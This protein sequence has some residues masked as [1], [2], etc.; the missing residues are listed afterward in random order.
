MLKHGAMFWDDALLPRSIFLQ[1]FDAL[2]KAIARSGE[3]AWLI[4]GDA[5]EYGDLA[6]VSHFL[7]RLRSAVALVVKD[8]P[9]TLMA[10][11]GSRDIPATKELTWFED[12][13][14]YWQ[15]PPELIRLVRD[16]GLEKAKIGTVGTTELLPIAEW[17]AISAELPDVRW[18]A[19][20]AAFRELR[21]APDGTRHRAILSA[22]RVL[23]DAFAA[24]K[25]SLRAGVTIRRAT[26]LIDRAAR[27]AA[28]EDVRILVATGPQCG[29]ALRP[30]DDRTPEAGDAIMLY[31]AVE[32]QRHWAS[33]ART[34]V[35][36]KAAPA[37]LDLCD[38]ARKAL[39]GMKVE[40]HLG[41]RCAD[42]A[43]AAEA[44]IAAPSLIESARSYGLG[45]G[46]GLDLE[47]PPTISVRSNEI[48]GDDVHLALD[49][50][51]HHDGIGI[52][53]GEMVHVKGNVCKRLTEGPILTELFG[54]EQSK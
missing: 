35:L 22:A 28:A 12:V 41:R 6:F 17:D 19:R 46:I 7:P 30:V 29:V 44:A 54:S 13:R 1:R 10:S 36:G 52:A 5:Q 48:I 49:I 4:Y 15:L 31:V 32:V 23:D 51:L 34:Y 20:D 38:R 39:A 33:A 2:Q 3:D 40:L 27:L 25:T 43:A 24:A 21:E 26:A 47:E 14:P 9:P 18:I 45:H 11:I 37:L 42:V 16:R 50:V 53:A 8:E